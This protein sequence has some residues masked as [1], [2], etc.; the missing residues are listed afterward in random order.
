MNGELGGF[1]GDLS[2][3]RALAGTKLGRPEAR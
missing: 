1:G 3:R 2:R